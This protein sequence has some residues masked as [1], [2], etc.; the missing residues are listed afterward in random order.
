MYSPPQFREHDAGRLF[1]LIDGHPLATLL[2]W[3]TREVAHL[4]LLLDR[5]RR[6][7][8]GHVAR[9]NPMAEGLREATAI[10][11][12]PDSYV[13]PAWYAGRAGVPTWNYAVVHVHGRGRIVGAEETRAI[14]ERLV[15]RH[16][17]EWTTAALPEELY[18][19]M[20]EEV[21]GFEIAIEG[22]EGKFKLSQNRPAADREGAMGG[23]LAR[24]H[25][26]LVRLMRGGSGA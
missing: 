25:A 3:R 11:R 1:D 20:L 12:G 22:I 6:V 2:D 14:L 7:L 23:L 5:A 18:E 15:A 8:L 21:A 10:F 24:G 4:P 26:E 17:R 16:D 19:E 9:A 13:S